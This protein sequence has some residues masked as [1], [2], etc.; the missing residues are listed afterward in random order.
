MPIISLDN[1]PLDR[2]LVLSLMYF[3]NDEARRK[4]FI[5]TTR[6]SEDIADASEGTRYSLSAEQIQ[7]LINA[8]SRSVMKEHVVASIKRATNAG[9]VL[10]CMYIMHKFKNKMPTLGNASIKQAIYAVKEFG[11]VTKYGDGQVLP[12][13]K[14]TIRS[15]WEEYKTVA[16]FWAAIRLNV[17]YSFA[18]ENDHFASPESFAKFL[19]VASELAIFGT[20]YC[21]GHTK[22]PK[23]LIDA[24]STWMLPSDMKP[25]TPVT[26]Q[27]PI[28]LEGYLSGYK[29]A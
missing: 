20:T 19:A 21:P 16:H 25:M 22:P 27:L 28:A 10:S 18:P 26:D 13:S 11:I 12:R 9:D 6:I 1:S 29:A 4:Q 17:A 14:T 24:E 5:E 15:N 8:P 3:P 23:P 2:L 7:V